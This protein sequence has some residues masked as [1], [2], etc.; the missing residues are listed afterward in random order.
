MIRRRA[1]LPQNLRIH[2]CIQRRA[3]HDLLEQVA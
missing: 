1:Q 3:R 2:A